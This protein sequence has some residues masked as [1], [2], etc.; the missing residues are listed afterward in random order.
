MGESLNLV[1]QIHADAY[2]ALL[3][4][5][6]N[7][8]EELQPERLLKLAGLAGELASALEALETGHEQESDRASGAHTLRN[9]ARSPVD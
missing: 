2:R 6:R 8:L 9:E 7:E 1:K 4:I 3:L 5:E